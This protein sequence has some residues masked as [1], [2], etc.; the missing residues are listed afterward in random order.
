MSELCHLLGHERGHSIRPFHRT[1]EDEEK[2]AELFG[3]TAKFAYQVALAIKEEVI[4]CVQ[5]P[6]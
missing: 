4:E 1:P 6:L 5:T 2:K 3:Q